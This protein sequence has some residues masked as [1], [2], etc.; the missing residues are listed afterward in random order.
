MSD[1]EILQSLRETFR[2]DPDAS[3]IQAVVDADADPAR[4]L[5]AAET[6][7]EGGEP[8]VP[9]EATSQQSE[10]DHE[11]TP[12][13]MPE[14][15][16]PWGDVDWGAPFR[17]TYPNTL[18]VREQ[19]MARD[20]KLPFAPWGDRDAPAE[21]NTSDC[22]A[23]R[24]DDPRCDCDARRKWGYEAFYRDGET[25]AMAEEDPKIDGRAFIQRADDPFSFVDGDDVRDPE[26]GA[27]HPAFVEILNRFGLTYADVSTSGAGVHAN[28][29][30]DL[31]N[32]IP[33]AKWIIDDEPWGTN[34]D[35]PAIEIYS[36]TH[37]C[38]TTGER[39]PGAA[40]DVREWDSD[41]VRRVLD[42]AGELRQTATDR[43][44]FDADDYEPEVTDADETTTEI[45]DIYHALDR[46]NAQ[47]VAED[48]IVAE[49]LEGRTEHRCFRPTWASPDYDGTAIY[50]DRD[51]FVD[52]GHRGGYGGAA[53]MAAIDAGLVSDT[54]CPRAVSGETWFEALAHLRD[55][56]GYSIP[57]FVG[58]SNSAA[59]SFDVT[60]DGSPT[61]S[62][63]DG[64]TT[65]AE[66]G[67]DGPGRSTFEQFKSDVRGAISAVEDDDD[68]TQRTARHRIAQ[69]FT[70]HYDFVYPEEEV[71][72]WRKVLYVYDADA[73]VYEPRGQA[74]VSNR[75]ERAAG[76]YNTNQ[77]TNEIVGKIKRMTIERG[78][79]F[80]RDPHRIA[81][82]NGILNLHT[83]DLDPF[84]PA[85][86]HRQKLEVAWNP[87]AGEPTAIDE[88]LHDI[89][90]D[91]DVATLYRLIAHT[92]Y[93]EYVGEKA[94]ILIGSGQNGKSVFLDVIEQFLGSYN[95]AHREL[96]DFDDDGFAAN[97]L[98]G[99]LA[100]L[101]TEI[102]E[103][104]LRDTTMFKKLTGRDTMD[105]PVKFEKPLTF[106][107]YA[108]LMFATNEM[109]VFGQDNHAVWRRWVYVDFPYTFDA[110]D[111]TAKDPEPKKLLMRRLTAERELEALLVRCQQEIQ[112][113]H[114]DPHT[115]FFAD[116]MAPDEVRDKMKKAAEPVYNFASTCLD[117]GDPEDTF[118]EKSVVRA[119]Y[120]AYADEED[121]PTLPEN[122]FGEQLV[123]LRDFPID[124]GQRRVD[125]SRTR[126]YEGIELSSRGRQVLGVD[127]TDDDD[128]QQVD[129]AQQATAVVI[130]ELRDM[131]EENDGEPVPRDGLEW[132]C[133]GKIGKATA[134][135][136]IDRLKDTGRVFDSGAGMLP[137][138]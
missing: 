95:V 83:G 87:D 110:T 105:A 35:L 60:D 32:D 136:A 88:F 38:V 3:P 74:F 97:N 133:S 125:G 72:G 16:G 48:T 116:A 126:V 79:A 76:D 67:D 93:K 121:L 63:T 68:M 24:A 137:T 134:S 50:C 131:V 31:P 59:P 9:P 111:P 10:P 107:N 90:E 103:Q 2:L 100:N 130:D 44:D 21:C 119:A 120:R 124:P 114:E 91:S 28:Y 18:L 82:A 55:D 89:V 65:A 25:V 69:A 42:E 81:V 62:A 51:K 84:S 94:A 112:R 4:W 15:D 102:G 47:R 135:N 22:P 30:G 127:E 34:D 138:E 43:A 61:E 20:G 6:L 53:A 122:T 66:A 80:E 104:Q 118:V 54:D 7:A 23:D 40:D 52:T 57:E 33:E 14:Y 64:G 123:S 113:W 85:E 13:P 77:V 78:P 101:A 29:K 37:V 17:D 39:L 71:R 92:V 46:L 11:A 70:T 115:E 86:Y 106:E 132:R 96:Q 1:E 49:W 128:Q 99:K 73:G 117:V 108:T 58:E 41:A 45:R 75:L 12:A 19:W 56:L 8:E 26:T 5:D 36:N 109:P 129:D 98:E 27:V